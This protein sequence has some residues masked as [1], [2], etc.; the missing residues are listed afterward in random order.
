MPK[1][2][3]LNTSTHSQA[4]LLVVEHDHTCIMPYGF[5]IEMSVFGQNL[6]QQIEAS[7]RRGS[8]RLAVLQ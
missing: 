2:N 3:V 5:R 6:P 7:L 8:C 1:Q 4:I